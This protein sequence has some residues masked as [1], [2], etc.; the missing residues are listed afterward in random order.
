[1]KIIV[2]GSRDITNYDSVKK[3]I[4]IGRSFFEGEITEIVSGG[5][6]GVDQLGELFAFY[7][8][9]PI[10]LFEAQWKK[11]GRA[12]GPIRNKEMAKYADGLIALLPGGESRG[13]KN[14]IELAQKANIPVFIYYPDGKFDFLDKVRKEKL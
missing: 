11:Y 6:R 4:K 1:M 12:A 13:T 14:M 2:A 5:C 10:K 3:A 7:N 8:D 9:L